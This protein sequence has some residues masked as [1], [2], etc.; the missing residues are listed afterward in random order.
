MCNRRNRFLALVVLI[1][2]GLAG[3]YA[4]RRVND[5][6]TPSPHPS[7]PD[8]ALVELRNGNARFVANRRVLSVDTARD[9]Q[10]RRETALGQTSLRDDR[11][12]RG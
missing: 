11:L 8:E 6:Y 2:V 1:V 10:C 5:R 9:D 12:L 3:A 4:I 7:D